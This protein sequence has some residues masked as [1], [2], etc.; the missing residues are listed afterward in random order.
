MIDLETGEEEVHAAELDA[1]RPTPARQALGL[2]GLLALFAYLGYRGG[3]GVL[4]MVLL[5]L[6]SVIIHEFG[7]FLTAKASGMKVTEFFIGFGP[8]IWSFRVGE[9]EYGVKPIWAGAYVRIIGMNNLDEVPEEDEHRTYRQQAFW[10]RLL[11]VLGGPLANIAFAFVLFAGLFA[12]VGQEETDR[13]TVR[14]VVEFTAAADAGVQVGDRILAVGDQP[15]DEWDNLGAVVEANPGEAVDLFIERD[16]QRIVLPAVIGERLTLEAADALDG[17]GGVEV[18]DR[19]RLIDGAPIPGYEDLRARAI[20]GDEFTVVVDRHTIGKG[21]QRREIDVVVANEIPAEGV[22]GF[23]GLGPIFD[24]VTL[25]PV[26]SVSEAA[27]MTTTMIGAATT[28]ILTVFSPSGLNNFREQVMDANKAKEPTDPDG[29]SAA[30]LARSEGAPDADRVVSI[31]GVVQIGGQATEDSGIEAA[32]LIVAGL[33]IFLAIL[34]L[35]PL[36]P[37]DGG[38]AA[39]VLYEGIRSKLTGK[40]HR[41]DVAKMLP[42][43]YTVVALFVSVGLA[44]IFLDAVNPV[45][46]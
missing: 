10:Q 21:H 18:G 36:L 40:Q 2:A 24:R 26:A 41:A 16:G 17:P 39:I 22:T 7:H 25:S 28:G 19:V 31:L 30:R 38:H 9:T 29:S 43:A 42:V 13:W 5:I 44:A 20:P 33:N 45:T 34:N 4:L 46:G 6:L 37:F 3:V 8:R 27:G 23:I 14:E 15:V 11:T 12:F 35:I 32:L 1:A